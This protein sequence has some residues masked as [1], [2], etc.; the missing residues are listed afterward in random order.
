MS[1]F[2]PARFD[3]RRTQWGALIIGVLALLVSAIGAFIS[4]VEFL[5]S[6]LVAYVFWIGI[7]LGSISIVLLHHLVG[8]L[9]GFV[10]RRVLE[11]GTRTLPLMAILALPILIGLPYLYIWAHEEEVAHSPL[12][13]EKA[14]YL[15]VPFFVVRMVLYFAIWLVLVFIL[16][17][18]SSR[19]DETADPVYVYRFRAFSGP[20]LI[21][22]GFVV[23]FAFIDLVMSIQP[24]WF[25]TIF[26]IIFLVGQVLSTLAFS[27]AMLML[28]SARDP[29]APVLRPAHFHDLGNLMLAFVIL[30]AYAA[31]SQFIII[32]SGNLPEEVT[33]YLD[34]STPG[35]IGVTV[36]L[37]IFHFAVPFFILLT[38][39][40]KRRGELLA[41]L[42]GA[43]ILIRIVDIHW[44]IK[45]S[46]PAA[47]HWMDLLIPI[48][49]GGIWLAVF[50]WQLSAR[51]LLPLH[52][53][54]FEGRV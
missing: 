39:Y 54:R 44:L 27:I 42:A 21:V 52:D 3:V 4:P 17:R 53:A 36:F 25:S 48:G 46:F 15:N 18:W 23:T 11:S 7:A 5:R 1:I 50:L 37:A 28:L 41:A 51:P 34:R 24:E 30:W 12:L 10:I 45:P 20:A 31:V 33:W 38:R 22:H 8:G 40:V 2:D 49:I 13:Q 6:Y 32:W 14:G 26:G 47:F 35:W 43:M 19:Q 29:L 16:N 9:W